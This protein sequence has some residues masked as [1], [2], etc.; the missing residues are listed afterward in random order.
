[1][2]AAFLVAFAAAACIAADRLA[3]SIF[4]HDQVVLKK[5]QVQVNKP[6]PAAPASD[7]GKFV[8]KKL[9]EYRP[10]PPF[11]G[12]HARHGKSPSQRAVEF[13][14]YFDGDPAHPVPPRPD[15]D[16]EMASFAEAKR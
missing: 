4:E 7:Q 3:I 5:S 9:A 2:R 8:A 10:R 1:M 14:H 13:A 15:L 11:P 6:I 12:I 16:K